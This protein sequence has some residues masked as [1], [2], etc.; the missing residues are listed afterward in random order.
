M[1]DCDCFL[2]Q[3]PQDTILEIWK[4][5]T[6]KY[7]AEMSRMT[8][9]RHRVL[10]SAPWYI[11]HISYGQDWR[12]S[13]AVQP[14]NFSGVWSSM[15]GWWL[16]AMMQWCNDFIAWFLHTV[17]NLFYSID[18]TGLHKSTKLKFI[19][20][21]CNLW[22]YKYLFLGRAYEDIVFCFF[23]SALVVCVLYLF[24]SKVVTFFIV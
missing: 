18:I 15:L 12:Y 11:N 16:T 14:Q 5:T 9:A 23:C 7:Q 17:E 2:S 21:K 3:I 20:K 1:W 13:Y 6:E 10:L 22:L 19:S 4:G 8:K 24:L